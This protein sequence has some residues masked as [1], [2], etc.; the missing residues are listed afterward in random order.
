MPLTLDQFLNSGAEPGLAQLIATTVD[1]CAGIA[2]LVRRGAVGEIMGALESENVQGEVQ[3]KLD[4]ISNDMLLAACAKAPALAAMASEEMDD[5]HPVRPIDA[6]ARY[7]LL[8]DP[9]DGSSNIDVNVSIGTIFS[10][11]PAKVDAARDATAAD[12]LQPGRNQVAAGYVVYGPQTTLV[13]TLGQGVAAFTLDPASDQWLQTAEKVAVPRETK[14]FAINASNMR[15]WAPPVQRYIDECLAGDT[16][17]RGKNFNMRWI[18][19][20]VADVHRIM[21]RGGVFLY[22]WDKREPDRAG[23]LRLM[24]EA[25]PMSLLVEQAG[26]ASFAGTGRMLDIQPTGLHQRVSVMLGSA[27]EV[28]RLQALHEEALATA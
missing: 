4:V 24:Y 22:P 23:K 19:S 27:A 12:F 10:I 25:N 14:E 11:L 16:G 5:V 1:A 18:A 26:G 20:M 9:L 15:H 3:K 21:V 28:E 8:F 2:N 17:C 7:L 6:E 13:L